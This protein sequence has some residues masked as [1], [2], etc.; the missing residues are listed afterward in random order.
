MRRKENFSV[1]GGTDGIVNPTLQSL[2]S[3]FAHKCVVLVI[4]QV[5]AVYF[6]R[7]DR[8]PFLLLFLWRNI[9]NR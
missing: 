7:I 3:E 1:L 8:E 9:Q 5:V 6:L 2:G 4:F